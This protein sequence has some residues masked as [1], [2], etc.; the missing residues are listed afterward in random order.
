MKI[1]VY[2]ASSAAVNNWLKTMIGSE[3]RVLPL[4]PGLILF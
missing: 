3:A 2:C 4:R 1:C